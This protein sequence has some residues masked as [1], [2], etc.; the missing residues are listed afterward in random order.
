MGHPAH[1]F[2]AIDP[3]R[4]GSF[5]ADELRHVFDGWPVPLGFEAATA[6]PAPIASNM[7]S[8]RAAKSFLSLS[9]SLSPPL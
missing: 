9:L 8:E 1:F 4:V 2:I 7:M 6:L 3:G 5:G